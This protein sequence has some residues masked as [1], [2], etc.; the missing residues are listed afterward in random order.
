[1][2]TPVGPVSPDPN[3]PDYW[4]EWYDADDEEPGSGFG[5]PLR[6]VALVILIGVVALFVLV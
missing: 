5:W 2:P 4:D 1:M 3:D 6:L